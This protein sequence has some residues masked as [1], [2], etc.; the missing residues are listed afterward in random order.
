MSSDS[1]AV[2]PGTADGPDRCGVL[3]N[4][5]PC[6]RLAGHADRGSPGHDR[7]VKTP[8][9]E[10]TPEEAEREAEAAAEM[11]LDVETYREREARHADFQPV[12]IGH[13]DLDG[14]DK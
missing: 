5:R 7:R 2:L 8:M 1:H 14:D 3:V 11:G 6:V 10:Q 4:G 12:F 9:T 13:I